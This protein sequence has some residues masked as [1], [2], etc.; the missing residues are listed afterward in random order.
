MPPESR[1][2]HFFASFSSSRG[3]VI[4]GYAA[5]AVFAFV[6]WLYVTFPYQA[7]R[8]RV[9]SEAAAAGW[10]VSI[11]SLGPGLYGVTARDVKLRPASPAL[12]PAVDASV[13]Q[14]PARA[15][16]EITLA[17]VSARPALF[18]PGI[19]G[20]ASAFGGTVSG[21]VGLLGDLKVSA[22]ADLDV[23]D[24]ALKAATGVDASGSLEG[25]IHLTGIAVAA[26]PRSASGVDF[27]R[28]SG[29][30]SVKGSKLLVK[31]G[32]VPVPL[33]GQMTPMDLPRVSLGE[34][35]GSIKFDK[36]AGKIEKVQARSEDLQIVLGGTV[37]LGRRIDLSELNVELK[38]KTEP[39]LNKRLGM[40]AS[41]LTVLPPDKSD[42]SFRATT[43]T[44]FLGQPRLTGVAGFGR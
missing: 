21:S 9:T 32:N 6:F 25:E 10:T 34:L 7:V 44:G 27:S 23:S 8:D 5:F 22:S 16:V 1:L 20:R 17:S 11:G 2:E 28:A 15:P 24:P 38:V 30:I 14:P 12:Q 42:P 40:V 18:P 31:G 13:G 37:T 35:D 3:R 26:G 19:A 29:S 39:E 36:G 43:I 4:A 41:A 33:Y